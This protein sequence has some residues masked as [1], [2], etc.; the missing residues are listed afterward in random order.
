MVTDDLVRLEK[1]IAYTIGKIPRPTT[2]YMR[3]SSYAFIDTR[4]KPRLLVSS[5]NSCKVPSEGLPPGLLPKIVNELPHLHKPLLSRKILCLAGKTSSSPSSA[6]VFYDQL[7]MSTRARKPR[8]GPMSYRAE[9]GIRLL[10]MATF[11]QDKMGR[12]L[13]L[14][15]CGPLPRME[16]V[17]C[18]SVFGIKFQGPE[19]KGSVACKECK[20]C[21]MKEA[22]ELSG[23]LWSWVCPTW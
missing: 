20:E 19:E 9:G 1:T 16:L 10:F 22:R 3:P 6:M 13:H 21:F 14:R 5:D 15:R 23:Q 11:P 4:A 2:L 12:N 8:L 17:C 7:L 18:S